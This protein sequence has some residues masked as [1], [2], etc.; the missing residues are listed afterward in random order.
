MDDTLRLIQH[1]YGEDVDDPAFVQRLRE[2]EALRRE[3]EELQETKAALDR[4]ASPSPDADVV[5]NIMDH[6]RETA[7][8]DETETREPAPDRAARAPKHQHRR[9]LQGVS[10]VL[11]LLLV[12]GVG[13]WQFQTPA[14][15][16]AGATAN[17]PT[18]QSTKVAPAGGEPDVTASDDMPEWDDRDE[19]VRLHRRIEMLHTQN[20][21]DGWGGGSLQ[22]VDRTGP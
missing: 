4:R 21:S 9:R 3:Y 7:R 10:A 2:D 20:H 14:S 8:S 6:A 15:A 18:A 1:L 19:V 13:W 11:A 22:A 16:P 5:D 17:A 12:A